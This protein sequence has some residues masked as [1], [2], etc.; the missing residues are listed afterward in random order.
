[1][2]NKYSGWDLKNPTA[3]LIKSEYKSRKEFS[4]G[5]PLERIPVFSISWQ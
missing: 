1:M 2:E 5:I 3:R 4:D